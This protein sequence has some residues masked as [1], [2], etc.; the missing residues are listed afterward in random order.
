M[1]RRRFGHHLSPLPRRRV[2]RSIAIGKLL[3]ISAASLCHRKLLSSFI[4]FKSRGHRKKFLH[5][6]FVCSILNWPLQI[7]AQQ[8]A[9]L[10]AL[11]SE[12][13]KMQTMTQQMVDQIFSFSE[14]DFQEFETSRYVTGIHLRQLQKP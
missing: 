14:L 5:I 6:L 3:F 7:H 10:P 4:I 2:S 8:Q 13:D 12:V 9:S 1:F 11:K